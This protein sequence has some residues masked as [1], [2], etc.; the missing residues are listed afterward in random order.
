MTEKYEGGRQLPEKNIV[1]RL[2]EIL[3]CILESLYNDE[4][5]DFLSGLSNGFSIYVPQKL[6]IYE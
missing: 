4:M 1:C 3:K 2:V 5:K 6:D